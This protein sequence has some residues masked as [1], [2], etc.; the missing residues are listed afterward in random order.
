MIIR[1][2]TIPRERIRIK[3]LMIMQ[4]GTK[5]SNEMNFWEN[6]ILKFAIIVKNLFWNVNVRLKH[7]KIERRKIKD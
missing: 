7:I 5:M 6:W 2:E 3:C 4:Q 1:E